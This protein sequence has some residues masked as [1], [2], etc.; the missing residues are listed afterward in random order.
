MG[1]VRQTANLFHDLGLGPREVVTYLLPNLPQ[2]HFTLRPDSVYALPPVKEAV[3]PRR[4]R[5]LLCQWIKTAYRLLPSQLGPK[6][7]GMRP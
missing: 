5:P 6:K 4:T 1:K 2:T 7:R 3:D